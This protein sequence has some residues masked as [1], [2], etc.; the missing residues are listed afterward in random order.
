MTEEEKEYIKTYSEILHLMFEQ[1]APTAEEI[2]ADMIERY[3]E[4]ES[5]MADGEDVV[6]NKGGE[7]SMSNRIIAVDFDGTLCESAWPEIGQARSSVIA[8]VLDQQAAGAKLILWT[9]RV[10]E[11]LDEAVKWCAAH[12]LIFDAVNENLPEIVEAFGGDT[13]KVFA[14]VYLD[15]RAMLPLPGFVE[16]RL[17]SLEEVAGRVVLGQEAPIY[18]EFGS[19]ATNAGKVIGLIPKYMSFDD[20]HGLSWDVCEGP[21]QGKTDG[22]SLYEYNIIW[23]CWTL[24]PTDMQKEAKEWK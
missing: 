4:Y 13:R 12:G 17:L 8:Y 10:G 15:D 14:N 24:P 16:P 11:R 9:N 19:L 3:Q 21:D 7:V 18:M 6:V 5:K 2:E 23:R 22:V 20:E 1:W